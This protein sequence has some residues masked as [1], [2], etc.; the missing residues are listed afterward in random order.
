[1]I[2]KN[3]Q[4]RERRERIS[5]EAI[6]TPYGKGPTVSTHARTHCVATSEAVED[7]GKRQERQEGPAGPA[8]PVDSGIM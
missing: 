5:Q 4:R 3:G 6:E 2:S 7:G 8:D 1:M